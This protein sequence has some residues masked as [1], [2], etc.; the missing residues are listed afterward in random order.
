MAIVRG[1]GKDAKIDLAGVRVERDRGT[2]LKSAGTLHARGQRFVMLARVVRGLPAAD[3]F[4]AGKAQKV[5]GEAG[6]FA[7][8]EA[9]HGIALGCGFLVGA[10]DTA[11]GHETLVDMASTVRKSKAQYKPEKDYLID[12]AKG[13]SVFDLATLQGLMAAADGYVKPQVGESDAAKARKALERALKLFAESEDGSIPAAAPELAGL[14]LEAGDALQ[15]A[16]A[17]APVAAAA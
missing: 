14:L 6:G 1:S 8:G 5:A 4:L 11:E 7:E 10:L 9:R 12:C 3:A 13:R 15:A 16:A 17:A 2:L